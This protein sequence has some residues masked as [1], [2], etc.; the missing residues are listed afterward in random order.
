MMPAMMPARVLLPAPLAPT[1]ATRSPGARRRRDVPQHHRPVV[2]AVL[3][4]GHLQCRRY[5]P[6]VAGGLGAGGGRGVRQGGDPDESGQAGPGLQHRVRLEQQ[7]ADGVEEAVEVEGGSGGGADGGQVT[8]DQQE[9]G[10]QH[11]GEPHELGAV[12]AQPEAG[13]ETE[14][15]QRQVA[16]DAGALRDPRDVGVLHPVG[17]HGGRAPQRLGRRLR[18]LARRHPLAG[19]VRHRPL[20]VPAQRH[21]VRRGRDQPGDAEPPVEGEEPR[22]GQHDGQQR[23]EEGGTAGGD[24]IRHH[25]HVVAGTG[26]QVPGP[27]PLQ[28]G[29]RQVQGAV[30]DPLPESGQ[31]GLA[32]ARGDRRSGRG[33]E[34]REHG[35]ARDHAGPG[36]HPRR[37]GPGDD[38]VDEAAEHPGGDQPGRGG[39]DQQRAGDGAEPRQERQLGTE[40]GPGLPAGG[41]RQQVPG[42]RLGRHRRV[43][44][45]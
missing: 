16:G 10:E 13:V 18:A 28:G 42:D 43:S 33:E 6:I 45:R 44:S 31:H 29:R 41:R 37:V 17:A 26:H 5:A 12:D 24:H 25:C 30:E 8:A 1:R 21:R 4:D 19:V 38:V 39:D 14:D 23:A 35:G 3:P 36:D 7:Q 32:E 34:P 40:G 20:E 2:V 27:G 11:G 22:R 9:A 15:L